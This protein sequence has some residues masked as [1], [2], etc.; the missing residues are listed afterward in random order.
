MR[1]NRITGIR[2]ISLF[3]VL[4]TISF[5]GY[6]QTSIPEILLKGT[7]KEQFDYIQEKTRI[8]EDFR[9][10]REDMFRLIKNNALDSLKSTKKEIAALNTSVR[11]RESEI[12]SLNSLISST[13]DELDLMTRT[14]NSFN[15][16]GFEIGKNT[17]NSILW[18][19]IAVLAILL[20]TGFVTYK[21][22]RK[23]A[24]HTRKEIEELRKEFEAYRQASREAR[25]KMSMAHFNE[26]KKLRGA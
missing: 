18:S 26:L 11:E 8:Y 6:S 3:I 21:R 4:M 24:I 7:I 17:Y 14:K 5:S 19:V 15:L 20:A 23:I 13:R 2:F 22:N 1:K 16:M 9:A 10:I 12:D 25:E